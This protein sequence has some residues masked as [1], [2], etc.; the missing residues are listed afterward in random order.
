M[1]YYN[2]MI[3]EIKTDYSIADK[4]AFYLISSGTSRQCSDS[5]FR[6]NAYD[7]E[8]WNGTTWVVNNTY[9]TGLFMGV[10]IPKAVA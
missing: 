8:Y 9:K 4:Q 2:K 6:F 7:L 5:P 3:D 10:Y 1:N